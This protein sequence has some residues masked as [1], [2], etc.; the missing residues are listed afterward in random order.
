MVAAVDL[1]FAA[2]VAVCSLR[3]GTMCLVYMFST[4]VSPGEDRGCGSGVLVFIG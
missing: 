4:A 1:A 2:V 3:Y